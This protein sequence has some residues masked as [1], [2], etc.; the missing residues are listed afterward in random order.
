MTEEICLDICANS[1]TFVV[2]VIS[3]EEHN[4]VAMFHNNDEAANN[5]EGEWAGKTTHIMPF[6]CS[7]SQTY[8]T[9]MN[10]LAGLCR[11]VGTPGTI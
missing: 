5:P 10:R 4:F 8:L 11:Q 1:L 6:F 3:N 9:R 7:P 2:V